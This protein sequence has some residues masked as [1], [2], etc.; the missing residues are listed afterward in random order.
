MEV[1]LKRPNNI[2]FRA[3]LQKSLFMQQEVEYLEFLFTTEGIRS[4]LKKNRS[5]DMNQTAYEFETTQTI[6]WHG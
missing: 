4:Q 5:N 1:V 2:G 6:L 3:N